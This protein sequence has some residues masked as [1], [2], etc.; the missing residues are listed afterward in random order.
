[1]TT[2]NASGILYIRQDGSDIQYSPN[3]SS[4][5]T[6]S[7]WPVYINNT[8]YTTNTILTVLYTT[9]I[10]TNL[11]NF[12]FNINN[13]YITFDG[14][15]NGAVCTLEINASIFPGIFITNSNHTIT[16]KNFIVSGTGTMYSISPDF[17]TDINSSPGFDPAINF[18]SLENCVNK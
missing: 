12:E 17:A 5:T 3:N 16:I 13:P 9:N 8:S 1:M 18:C 2:I 11:T 6:I 7:S 4:W 10:T 14:S 15:Y